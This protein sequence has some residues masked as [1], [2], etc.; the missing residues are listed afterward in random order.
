MPPITMTPVQSSQIHS[1]GFDSE[2]NT[3]H[4]RFLAGRGEQRGPGALYQYTGVSAEDFAAFDKA[5]SKGSYFGKVFK[6]AAD[7]FPFNRVDES[8][9]DE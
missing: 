9:K 1:I 7:R 2:T 6:P 3:M 4:V 8:K 5:E